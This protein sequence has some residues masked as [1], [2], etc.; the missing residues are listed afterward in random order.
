MN[1]R[2][3]SDAMDDLADTPSMADALED[4]GFEEGDAYSDEMGDLLEDE[5]DAASDEF[6]G[7]EIDAY[8]EAADW[9]DENELLDEFEALMVDALDSDDFIGALVGGLGSLGRVA[10]SLGGLAR[11]VG[12]LARGVGSVGRVVGGLG[13][14]AGSIG[15][16]VGGLG[17][18]AGVLGRAGRIAGQAGRVVGRAGT[19]AGRVAGRAGRVARVGRIG[20]VARAR[21][22]GLR[23]RP[24]RARPMGLRPPR[25]PATGAARR[26]MPGR[27][28]MPRRRGGGGG[29][30]PPP[31]SQLLDRILPLLEDAQAQGS[32]E[33][34][35]TDEMLDWFAEDEDSDAAL[36]LIAGLAARAVARPLL[37]AGARRLGRPIAGQ[38]LRGAT[39]AARSLVQ[40]QGR[41]AVRA[42]APIARSVGRVAVRRGTPPRQL[43][44]AVAQTAR[45]VAAQPALARRITAT[46]SPAAA[47]R[48][49]GAAPMG[50]SRRFRIN[51]PVEIIVH[52]R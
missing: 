4:D 8:D 44:R 50:S 35:V 34:E 18:G 25:R 10:G 47:S 45:Q 13:R 2:F 32:D 33:E 20:R 14:S 30:A 42:L 24:V 1:D 19:A 5:G 43:P 37:R 31:L 29:E 49:R 6:Y 51:G 26:P 22:G 23:Y 12:G 28:P 3:D 9:A 48:T 46:V 40:S 41:R 36:P 15:R 17:R 52:H 38:L 39:S 27:R 11:G 16:V 21:P 7:D